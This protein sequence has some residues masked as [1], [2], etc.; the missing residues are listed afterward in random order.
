M[1]QIKFKSKGMQI[2]LTLMLGWGVIDTF[3]R[4]VPNATVGWFVLACMI[5]VIF[6]NWNITTV[7]K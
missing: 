3:L 1:N 2:F 7:T 6:T 4:D 5:Y